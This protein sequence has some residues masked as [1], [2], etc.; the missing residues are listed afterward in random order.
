M[1]RKLRGRFAVDADFGGI[2]GKGMSEAVCLRS[3][4]AVIA[5]HHHGIEA[6]VELLHHAERMACPGADQPDVLRKH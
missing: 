6:L 4:C 1:N 2:E 5:D 3:R